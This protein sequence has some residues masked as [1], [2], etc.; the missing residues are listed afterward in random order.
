MREER[1]VWS[2]LFW[3]KR[4]LLMMKGCTMEV[5]ND[6]I[7]SLEW[8]VSLFSPQYPNFYFHTPGEAAL[9]SGIVFYLLCYKHLGQGDKKVFRLRSPK[10]GQV[11]ENKS[12]CQSSVFIMTNRGVPP[13]GGAKLGNPHAVLF[14]KAMTENTFWS[15]LLWWKQEQSKKFSCDHMLVAVC[16]P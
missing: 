10:V 5:R 12:V 13:M 6:L 1:E 16:F 9:K 15:G 8:W 14:W 4:D 7:M 3:K 11:I 2:M